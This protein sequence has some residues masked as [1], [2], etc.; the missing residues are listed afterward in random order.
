MFSSV[1]RNNARKKPTN[2]FKNRGGTS[3]VINPRLNFL[4]SVVKTK[5]HYN[6]I[7]TIFKNYRT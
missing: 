5:T 4:K 3:A 6:P 1:Q 7:L 2:G